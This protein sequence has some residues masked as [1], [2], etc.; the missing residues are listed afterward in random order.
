VRGL[1][2]YAIEEGYLDRDPSALVR[3]PRTPRTS[4]RSWLHPDDLLQLLDYASAHAD[5]A[6]SAM[7][8]LHGLCGTRPGETRRIDVRDI[9]GYGSRTALALRHRKEGASDRITVSPRVAGEL[10]RAIADRRTG[11][12]LLNAA[13]DRIDKSQARE[14]VQ[15]IVRASGVPHVTPYGLR[16]GFIIIALSA[17]VPER[18][19]MH[20]VGH[21]TS[22]QTAYYD[23][24]RTTIDSAASSTVADHI[25][26]GTSRYDQT[27]RPTPG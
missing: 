19:V 26:A 16:T 20:Y 4:A 13:G 1:Y 21:T 23:R 25:A 14:R 11:P 15:K 24:L 6:T 27:A 18:E 3:L 8:H 5:P 7:L 17:G 2:R 12:L 22:S 10:A 9:A